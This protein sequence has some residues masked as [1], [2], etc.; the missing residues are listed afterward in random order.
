M[1]ELHVRV[2]RRTRGGFHENFANTGD[3]RRHM[4]DKGDERADECADNVR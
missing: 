4:I 1:G 2:R 3:S